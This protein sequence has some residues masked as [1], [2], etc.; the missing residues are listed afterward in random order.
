LQGHNPI[1][2]AG[3]ATGSLESQ[4]GKTQGAQLLASEALSANIAKVKDS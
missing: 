1:A 3:G 2:V 4:A